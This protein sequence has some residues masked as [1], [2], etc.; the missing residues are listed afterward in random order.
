MIKYVYL[1]VIQFGVRVGQRS[2]I[3]EICQELY[4]W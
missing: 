1:F 4:T 3:K 2:M